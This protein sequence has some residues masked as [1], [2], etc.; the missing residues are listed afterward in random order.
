MSAVLAGIQAI[1]ETELLQSEGRVMSNRFVEFLE[2]RQL[3][4]AAPLQLN[5][6]PIRHAFAWV[7][8]DFT[9]SPAF[10]FIQSLKAKLTS[11]AKPVVIVTKP[12]GPVADLTGSWTGDA[13]FTVLFMQKTYAVSLQITG[14]IGQKITGSVTVDGHTFSGTFK[15]Y[16]TSATGP[17]ALKVEKG[18]AS[19]RINGQLDG[20]GANLTG[21]ITATYSGFSANGTFALHKAT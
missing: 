18:S 11:G 17:F 19:V 2:D 9:N 3:F 10:K 15:G 4:A 5:T 16:P 21:D 13:T 7:T 12:T 14:Q 20:A 8:A 6:A 1:P